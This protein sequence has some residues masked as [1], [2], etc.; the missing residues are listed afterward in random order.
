[1]ICD[2]RANEIVNVLFMCTLDARIVVSS[3]ISSM[4]KVIW[5]IVAVAYAIKKKILYW[6][7]N[8]IWLH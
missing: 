3:M 2:I 7:R 1:M 5:K 4:C 6:V 8:T